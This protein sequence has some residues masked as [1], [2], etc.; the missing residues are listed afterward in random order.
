M[1]AMSDATS[2]GVRRP[3]RLASRRV[4]MGTTAVS[5]VSTSRRMAAFA[6]RYIARSPLSSDWRS[7][8]VTPTI[9][10]RAGL[11]RMVM[12]GREFR[13]LSRSS[14]RSKGFQA[15]S[16]SAIVRFKPTRRQP[17]K[18]GAETLNYEKTSVDDA[19]REMTGGRGPDV[20]IE[21]IGLEAHTPG[22]Q[23]FYDWVKQQTYLQTDRPDALREAIYACRKGGTV[24]ALGVFVGLV[25]KFPM[26]ALMNKGLTLRGAQQHG[27][28]YIPMLLERMAPG[29]LKTSHLMTHPLPLDDGPRGYDMFK[30]KID[31]CVRA[32]F[33]P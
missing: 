3:V 4:S 18:I 33:Q 5:R 19:L 32:V 25:D 8:K 1:L 9:G 14:K 7:I 31:G 6:V 22:P 21:A 11:A 15:S 26:G 20:C 12:S 2:A 23:L 10:T 30:N 17:Q 24:F 16:D 29:E 28:R 13:G 27:E